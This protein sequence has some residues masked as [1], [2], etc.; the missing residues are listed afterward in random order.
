[1]VSKL[2][3][4]R[5]LSH[6]ALC[7]LGSA[8]SPLLQGA[9]ASPAWA[10]SGN[11][12]KLLLVNLN[13]GYD[14]LALLQ[15]ISGGVYSTLASMRPT[16]A[17]DPST[18]LATNGVYGLDPGLTCLKSIYDEGR[19]A[20]V[21]KV[22]YD[23]MSRSHLDSEVVYA[24]GVPDRLSATASGFLTRIGGEYQWGTL[25]AISVT[26][27]DRTFEGG[28]YRGTQV[29]GLSS[30]RFLDQ[31]GVSTH[32]STDRKDMAYSIIHDWQTIEAKAFQKATKDSLEL[33]VNTVDTVKAAVQSTTYPSSYPNTWVAAR[34]KDIET[35]FSASQIDA[36]VGY[37]RLGGY[38]T[39]STQ[40]SRL[41]SLVSQINA[42]LTVFIANMKTRG[43]WNN[44]IIVIFSEFGRTNRENGSQG[45]DHGGG[46]P[47][48]VLGGGVQG[49][50]HGEI[51]SADLTN[52]G[53]LPM[54]YNLVSVYRQVFQ[55]M[56]YDSDRIFASPGGSALGPLFS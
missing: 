31:N 53:W 33:T 15:P 20:G 25:Q 52:Y 28:A 46:A 4:R 8:I 54:Q 5:F 30:F 17:K 34:F 11:G 23:N 9:I 18:L 21:Q 29:S 38:D 51:T 2:S 27:S 37:L 45:T 13:G 7:G 55:K 24:R 32:E 41:S 43:M 1:M 19:L 3:R 16:L 14:G 12:T 36:Q 49:G 48:F 42:A 56:G 40:A 47:I 44:L 26:G 10:S 39:H 35:A 6:C 22:G 50:I